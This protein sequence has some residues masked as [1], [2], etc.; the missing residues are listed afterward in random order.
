MTQLASPERPATLTVAEVAELLRRDRSE[1]YKLI[2]EDRFPFPHVRV[3][4]LAIRIPSA[5]IYAFL[6]GE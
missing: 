5:P 2:R 1:L 4:P 6:D 3:G